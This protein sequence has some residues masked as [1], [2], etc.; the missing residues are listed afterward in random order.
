[1]IDRLKRLFQPVTVNVSYKVSD[2]LGLGN[3]KKESYLAFDTST[4][5]CCMSLYIGALTGLPKT[6]QRIDG[7]TDLSLRYLSS[8]DHPAVKIW[9]HQANDEM[10]SDELIKNIGHDLLS[11]GNFYA[12]R[13]RNMKG[14]TYQL[15]YI[16]PTRIPRGNIL[17]ATGGEK[18]TTGRPAA[19]G[20]LIYKITVSS[21]SKGEADEAMVLPKEDVFHMKSNLPDPE[22]FR[23]QGILE[24]AQRTFELG[25]AS[26]RAATK[27]YK[28]GHINQMFL[29][30]DSKL[31]PAVKKRVEEMLDGNSADLSIEDMFK[32]RILEHGLKPVHVGMPLEQMQFIQTKAF[33]IED[34]ARW[35]SIPTALIHSSLGV[36]GNAQD[37]DKQMMFWIQHGLGNFLTNISIGFRNE[38][39]PA[40][41]QTTFRFD[42]RRLHLYKTLLNELSQALR[43]LFEIGGIDRSDVCDII[44]THIDP[45]DPTNQQR[46]VPSNL[47]TVDHSLALE[48]KA[49][50]SI[51][52]ME[53]TIEEKKQKMEMVEKQ[54]QEAQEPTSTSPENPP[55]AE[56][57]DDPDQSASDENLDN[58]LVSNSLY[59]TL[60][61]FNNHL[62][63]VITQKEKKENPEYE[64]VNWAP[65]FV[66]F[67]ATNLKHWE[68]AVKH[69]LDTDVSNLAEEWTSALIEDYQEVDTW[70]ND[71][72]NH[73]KDNSDA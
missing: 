38:A 68:P 39:V 26:E 17:R 42:Y 7:K 28:R 55:E 30:T 24:H 36:Q 51:E 63:R 73:L 57:D 12:L 8:T 46:Y 37:I 25:D 59:A 3:G 32:T 56:T 6:A 35:F 1:M 66:E 20:E 71:K 50:K 4:Y 16:H 21:N 34:W 41:S 70:F 9:K 43:N 64:I 2:L 22:Y 19:R 29:S 31:G 33:T 40:T 45:M 53:Q 47:V 67:V 60:D 18:L 23:G 54:A 49:V 61:G 13:K 27:F 44:G 52:V 58:R 11:D 14:Q 72:F 69:L 10:S 62:H 15:F 5:H 65:K 48:Q